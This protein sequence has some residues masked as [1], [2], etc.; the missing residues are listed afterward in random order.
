[1][2]AQAILT[3]NNTSTPVF[4]STPL[5]FDPSVPVLVVLLPL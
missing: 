4:V 2:I 1:M 5:P 3:A